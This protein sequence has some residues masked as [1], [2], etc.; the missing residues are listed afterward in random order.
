MITKGIARNEDSDSEDESEE[1][2]GGFTQEQV[3]TLR[4]VAV[5]LGRDKALRQMEKLVLKEQAGGGMM[6]FNTSFS[7]T[8]LQTFDEFTKWY[9]KLTWPE[10]FDSLFAFTYMLGNFEV[11][12][13]DH[14]CDWAAD[15]GKKMITD[16]AKMWRAVLKK[17]DKTL[18]VDGEFTRPGVVALL[19][20]FKS[21]V[22]AIEDEDVT[23]S[24][25]FE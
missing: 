8:L 3:D 12:M 25:K 7:W 10:R 19:G 6:M 4:Y 15:G 11:W 22:E 17:D 24:F 14:E 21:N 23:L 16:L 1:P 9:T 13:H 18:K 20:D 2:E 5:T